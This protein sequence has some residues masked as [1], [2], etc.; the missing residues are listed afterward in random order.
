M[1]ISIDDVKMSYID[2]VNLILKEIS[3]ILIDK[4]IDSGAYRNVY[5][6]DSLFG[7]DQYVLK[8]ENGNGFQN[9]MEWNLWNELNYDKELSKWFAPCLK[10]SEHGKVL[11]QRK[12]SP[13]TE[14]DIAKF[15]KIPEYLTDTKKSNYGMIGRQ[16]VCHDYG[17]INI[18]MIMS[19]AKMKKPEWWEHE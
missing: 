18:S 10:I 7:G 19:K 6:V 3:N 16:L 15:D 5:E 4:P 8:I 14:K 2:D 13:L 9:I 12:T 1:S 11:I 17:L